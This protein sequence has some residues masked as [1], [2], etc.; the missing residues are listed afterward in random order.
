MTQFTLMHPQKHT[1][2]KLLYTKTIYVTTAS[3]MMLNYKV[4]YMNYSVKAMKW[5]LINTVNYHQ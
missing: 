3:N 1:L 4:K 2:L 5:R